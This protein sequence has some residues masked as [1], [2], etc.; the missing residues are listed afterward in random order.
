MPAHVH[1]DFLYLY[2]YVYKHIVLPNCFR[3]PTLAITN[4]PAGAFFKN[5]SFNV[6]GSETRV[7][8]SKSNRSSTLKRPF[9]TNYV[10]ERKWLVSYCE[11]GCVLDGPLVR[12]SDLYMSSTC[13]RYSYTHTL[14][15]APRPGPQH[16]GKHSGSC[17]AA[18]LPSKYPTTTY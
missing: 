4:H 17:E 3:R 18:Q 2:E 15:H 14:D 10:K 7:G 13:I 5:P 16:W 1:N 8:K 6:G 11:G 12:L 9:Q